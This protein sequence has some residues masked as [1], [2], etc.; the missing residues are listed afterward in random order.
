MLMDIKKLLIGRQQM[1][2]SDLA[3]HFYVSEIMMQDML[4]RWEKKGHIE[5]FEL[6]ASCGS[7]CGNCDEAMDSKLMYRWRNAAQKP[8]FVKASS[9]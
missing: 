9:A 1:S 7:G 5:S 2:L 6:D 8:I 3:R 4:S